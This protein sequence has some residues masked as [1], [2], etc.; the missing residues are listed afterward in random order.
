MR[1]DLEKSLLERLRAEN[2]KQVLFI[3]PQI[4]SC[5]DIFLRGQ[6]GLYL[7]HAVFKGLDCPIGNLNRYDFAIVADTV[8]GLKKCIAQQLVSQ[9][10]DLRADLLWVMVADDSGDFYGVKD[11]VAQGM[12][13]VSPEN[14]GSNE[15]EWYEF[16][17]RFYKP[18]PQ[19]LNARN[20]ANPQQWDKNRW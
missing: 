3:A 2:V 13:M 4:P 14:F 16:S 12:R 11:A 7:E 17:L 20:W 8:D 9:F 15:P 5:I 19:W 6:D 18:V 1:P 10:R